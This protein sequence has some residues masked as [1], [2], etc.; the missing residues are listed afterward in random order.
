VLRLALQGPED[1]KRPRQLEGIRLLRRFWL[2][3]RSLKRSDCTFLVAPRCVE[4]PARALSKRS[5]SGVGPGGVFHELIEQMLGSPQVA[6]ADERLDC[7]GACDL[8]AILVHFTAFREEG[9]DV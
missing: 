2:E 9:L 8:G 4:K 5:H 3:G 7:D 6:D 1:E